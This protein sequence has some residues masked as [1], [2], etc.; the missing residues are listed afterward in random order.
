MSENV[1]GIVWT[2]SMETQQLVNGERQ[3]NQAARRTG[4]NFDKLDDKSRTLNTSM[5]RLAKAIA[6]VFAVRQLQRFT[7]E[8]IAAI[9]EQNKFSQAIGVTFNQIQRLTFAAEQN[10]STQTELQNSLRRLARRAEEAADGTGSAVQAFRDLNINAKELRGLSPDQ[11]FLRVSDAFKELEDNGTR[12]RTAFGLFDTEG[13]KLINTLSL[14]ADG[15]QELGDEAQR[16]GRILSQQTAEDAAKFQDEMNKLRGAV[17]GAAV[18]IGSEFV[19]TMASAASTITDWISNGDNAR[20]VVAGLGAAATAT[21]VIMMSRLLPAII[22]NVT[23]AGALTAAATAARAALA[24][25]AGPAGLVALVA[26]SMVYLAINS[27]EATSAMKDQEGR[28]SELTA[29]YRALEEAQR[30]QARTEIQATLDRAKAARDALEQQLADEEALLQSA[31]RSRA[32]Q[33]G[34]VRGRSPSND[35][36][37]QRKQVER[38]LESQNRVIAEN[39]ARLKALD[40]VQEELAKTS[41]DLSDSI[42]DGSESFDELRQ[43]LVDAQR[44]IQST[45]DEWEE[46]RLLQELGAD[47]TKEQRDEIMSLIEGLRLLRAEKRA[48][49]K[50]ERQ[51]E[52]RQDAVKQLEQELALQEVKNQLGNDEYEIRAAIMALGEDDGSDD[53]AMQAER[54][55]T[56]VEQMQAL[57]REAELLGPSMQQI[58]GDA[59]ISALDTFSDGIFDVLAGTQSLGDALKSVARTIVSDLLRSIIRYY[60]GQAAA[61]LLG[62]TKTTAANVAA[63]GALTAAYTPAAIAANIATAGGAALSAAATAPIAAA[64]TSSAI[65]GGSILGPGRLNGGPVSPGMIYPITEDG[66]PEILKQGGQQYLLPGSRGEVVSNRNMQRMGSGSGG[67][68]VNFTLQVSRDMAMDRAALSNALFDLEPQV[69]EMWESQRYRRGLSE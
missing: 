33:G 41:E 17:R 42:K 26:S 48:A 27:R 1:G 59:G 14:G 28:V 46:Y 50:E 58:F 67:D 57:R 31:R 7:M 16:T 38:Q 32:M 68:T 66:R 60:V 35:L 5:T 23:A 9:D 8:T 11:I 54:I 49:E 3:V 20:Q 10:G 12:V 24:F 22:A 6:G 37:A 62:T 36:S 39:E 30:A 40:R 34:D 53:Y 64:A 69:Y 13:A 2:A 52:S 65:L 18:S 21:S 43:R 45:G 44:E 25:L 56:L 15:I 63:A 61:A 51:A 29:E 19:P 55:T 47:A 4:R